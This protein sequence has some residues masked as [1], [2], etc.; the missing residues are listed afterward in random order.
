[1]TVVTASAPILLL[2]AFSLL[3]R[4]FYAL[5]PLTTR[6]GV[7][8][9]ALY[10]LSVLLLKLIREQKPKGGAFALD[11]PRP[12]FRH[13]R[14]DGY[15]AS[16]QKPPSPLVQQVGRLREIIAAFGFPAL[17]SPGF[18]ADDVLATLATDLAA[19]GESPMVV[20]G[21]R[22]SLQLARDGARVLYVGRGVKEKCYDASE[23]EARFGVPPASLPDYVA[24]VGDPS[25]DLPGVKGIGL[26]TAARLVTTLGGVDGILARLPEVAPAR[27]QAAIAAEGD[28]L[29]LWRDLACLRV[30][31]PLPDAPKWSKVTPEA[32][33]N[34]RK[35]FV[36]L[37][38]V[39]LAARVDEAFA[40]ALGSAG[41]EA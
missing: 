15:K 11:L 29:R 1:M 27:A 19:A 18:E 2:D 10:G 38:F 40:E 22:D 12:T 33:E 21:D 37:E 9:S 26:K 25:D 20:S 8:T 31:V 36:E 32:R 30:D 35:L 16:R 41:A 39:S 3:Y 34:V 28:K 14:W 6:A 17:S 24:L 7:P 13:E 5:P 23:V 4:A